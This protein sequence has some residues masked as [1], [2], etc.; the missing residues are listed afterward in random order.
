MTGDNIKVPLKA[1]TNLAGSHSL[2]SFITFILGTAENDLFQ[3]ILERRENVCSG[4][5]KGACH[6]LP[7]FLKETGPAQETRTQV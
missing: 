4:N 3:T 6:S 7:M 5:A 2:A 1:E